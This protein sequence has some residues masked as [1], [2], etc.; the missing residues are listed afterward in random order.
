MS[1]RKRKKQ[2]AILYY[3]SIIEIALKR[4]NQANA[5]SNTVHLRPSGEENELNN[6]ISL[7]K[8]LTGIAF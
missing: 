8:N 2:N 3:C 5:L 6:L 1:L 7:T 4:M